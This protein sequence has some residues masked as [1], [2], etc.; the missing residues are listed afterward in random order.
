MNAQAL[1]DELN[2]LLYTEA[3][4]LLRH[5]EEAKPYVTPKTYGVWRQ[6]EVMIHQSQ[7][8]AERLS[9]L[10]ESIR[11]TP[12][13]VA[14]KAEVGALHYLTLDSL[15]PLIIDEK[16]RQIAAYQRAI[17]HAGA[18]HDDEDLREELTVLLAEVRVQLDTLEALRSNL[19]AGSPVAGRH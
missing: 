2:L 19:P 17:E 6:V 14:Y 7:Q 16:Q 12:K 18:S 13:P 5:L 10:L 1:A 3:R 4:S 9:D 11:T 8:H 15:L